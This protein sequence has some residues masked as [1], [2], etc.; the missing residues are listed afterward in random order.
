MNIKITADSTCDISRADLDKYN[1]DIFSLG[2]ILGGEEFKDGFDIFSGDMINGV[3]N[4]NKTYST[5][6]VSVGEYIDG[7]RKFSEE[8]D[9]V[10][11][12]CIGDKFSSCYRNA[13]IAS[14]EFENVYI[15]NSNHLSSGQGGLVLYAAEL[16]QSGLEPGEIVD[17]LNDTI[18]NI[19]FSF[20]IDGLDYLKRG[21]R[22]SA[23][24]AFGANL[25]NIKPCIETNDGVLEVGKKYRGPMSKC[26]KEY[27]KD[28]LAEKDH[29]DSHRVILVYLGIDEE[30]IDDSLEIIKSCKDF[31]D[32]RCYEAGCT[33]ASHC[34]PGTLGLYFLNK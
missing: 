24:T 33:I 34:G 12:I 26:V 11:H 22:C 3:E 5:A 10:I 2:V 27:I 16:A 15:V 1:I 14:H 4:D 30:I 18:K 31:D 28:Q 8:Y 23:I 17:I 32:V 20:I 21:G 25:L 7:F 6:A 13:F 29:I 9:A 19:R